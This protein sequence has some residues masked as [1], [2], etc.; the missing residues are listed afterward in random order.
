MLIILKLK[1]KINI[2]DP[3]SIKFCKSRK[4]KNSKSLSIISIRLN[5]SNRKE[6][7]M[8]K[9]LKLI[10]SLK[11]ILRK[12]IKLKKESRAHLLLAPGISITK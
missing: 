3:C 1:R 12:G 8:L 10:L 5:S 2:I 11:L 9:K 4:N 7:N 6:K